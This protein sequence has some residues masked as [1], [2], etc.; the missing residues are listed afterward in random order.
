MK[1][2]WRVVAGVVVAAGLVG[3]IRVASWEPV[4]VAGN[5]NHRDGDAAPYQASGVVHVHTTYS[6]G[7]GSIEEV[8]E[9]AA[10]AGLDF[11]IVTDHNTFAGKAL[12]GYIDG[13]LVLVGT[14]VSTT[15]GHLLGFGLPTPTFRFSGDASDA[16]ADINDLGGVAFVAHPTSPRRDFRWEDWDLPGA[17]GLEM[18][19]GDTQWR[20]SNWSR[21]V[22]STALY[23]L[24]PTY[25]LLRLLTRPTA[26]DRWD[27]LLA[28]RDVPAIAGSDSHSYIGLIEASGIPFPSYRSVFELARNHVV[29][30]RQPSGDA[31]EDGVAVV[32]ALAQG[33]SYIALDALAPADG[34]FFIAEDGGQQWSM[35]DTISPRPSLRL[36]AG[37]ALPVDA[38]VS[39][40]KDGH[41]IA[42][43]NGAVVWD[44]VSPGVYRIQVD[45]P[46]WEPH[47][48]LS[49]AI[50]V[51][52]P[53]VAHRRRGH[54]QIPLAPVPTRIVHQ[55]DPLDTSTAFVAANDPSTR[56]REDIVDDNA[57]PDGQEV[58]R[59]EFTLGTPTED[60]PSPFAAV[61]S[62]R[63]R[64]LSEGS[65]LTLSVKADGVYRLNVQLRDRN[66]DS[67]VGEGTEWWFA[68]I[69]T[70]TTWQRM[71]VP[72]S[73]F[74]STD[75]ATDGQLDLDEIEGLVLVVDLGTVP[76]Q[77]T[78]VIWFDDLSLYR[79]R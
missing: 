17:W 13:V 75:P 59:L 56:M 4:E 15:T 28:D 51:F 54:S 55:L 73:R 65:G 30:E 63:S 5:P 34:F 25:A 77:T 45:L 10:A 11:V 9:A 32:S 44:D 22:W 79:S 26:A 21:A 69:K 24:N 46:D 18:L 64:D 47:W 14:E 33:R 31:A 41:L 62:F 68:S 39:L 23:P 76:P 42:T 35:G 7:G 3:A 38:R 71:A 29:L 60:H 57:G 49:N 19:N 2:A 66:P 40:L 37:G 36:R 50:Y 20:S 16:L 78:G 72:F 74:R 61:T 48:I 70:S 6:D 43:E 58:V 67:T 53:Q 12:E 52:D 27:G 1:L 8:A